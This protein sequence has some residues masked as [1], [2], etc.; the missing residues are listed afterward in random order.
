MNNVLATRQSFTE[1]SYIDVGWGFI[2]MC[3]EENKAYQATSVLFTS[4]K[5]IML[6]FFYFILV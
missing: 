2:K 3:E 5:N 4:E 6:L 1:N